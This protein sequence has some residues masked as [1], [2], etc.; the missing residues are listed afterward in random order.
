MADS[1]FG[2]CLLRLQYKWSPQLFVG[3]L[4]Q[5]R[6]MDPI[7]PFTAAIAVI[8]AFALLIPGYLSGGNIV[9][10]SREFGEFGF[11]AIAE[12]IVIISGGID[13][14]V[15]ANFAI[16]NFVA[17]AMFNMCGLPAP[18]AIVLALAGGGLMGAVNGF[19]IGFVGLG[20]FLTTLVTM[21]IF[22]AIVNLLIL[23]Y[24][25]GMALSLGDSRIWDWLGGGS[26]LGAP[27]NILI[28]ALVAIV[29]HVFLS[30]GRPGWYIAAIGSNRRAARHAGIPVEWHL[31]LTYVV[32]GILAAL[33]GVFYAARVNSPT[34]DTGVG[35]EI[36]ALTAVVLGGVNL[37]GGKGTVAQALIG[38]T[39]VLVLN[40][41]LVRF[42]LVGGATWTFLG[43]M[44]LLAVG[45]DVKWSRNRNKA[46]DKI[47]V[48]PTYFK[49][50][51]RRDISPGGGSPLSL[52]NR[53]RDAE[54]IGLGKLDGPED[55]IFDRA[56]NL[57]CGTREGF[58]W[59]FSGEGFKTQEIFARTGGRPLGMAFDRDDNLIICIGGMGVYGV[60]PDRSVYK[61]TDE[62]NR[63]FG[64]IRDDSRLVL[65][66]DLD[67]A[68]DGKIYF[69]E[70]TLRYTAATWATDALEGR[71]NGRIIVFDPATNKTR[72]LLRD[73]VFP[74]GVCVAHDGQSILFALTW[75]CRIERYWIAGPKAGKL[76]T[77]IGD[78]PGMPDN[79]NRASDG[80]YWLA[81]VG[82]RTPAHDLAMEYPEFRRRMIKRIPDDE[83]LYPNINNG[84]VLKFDESGSILETLGDIG[85]KSHPS[86]TSMREER[87]YLYIGGLSND[88][89]GRVKLPDADPEW[90]GPTAYWGK[91]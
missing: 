74:N 66:D 12:A 88:R 68:P 8:V 72:T 31:F 76:E 65:A 13:L 1:S 61:L 9:A 30:R 16:A 67:I 78:L 87:G 83:W 38:A 59:R 48:V 5:K 17:L 24:S 14:S 15:G 20:A 54:A 27:S 39:I 25:L 55:V 85:G 21:L 3:E 47:Y 63:T 50:G 11:V 62:T 86:V 34:S 75:P 73:Q 36:L 53:L 91:R 51:Q 22:R 43:F 70:A 71:G 19:L 26:V 58:I 32:A 49:L 6:W 35:M 69:S 29:G 80:R 41:G 46:I 57:Y 33:G 56:G 4:L 10:T 82:L 79:I 81:L 89:I 28:L 90:N 64:K 23:Q 18:V 52:N 2:E 37:S 60:R 77:L 40:N 45:I 44:M 84:C 42:G 7:V